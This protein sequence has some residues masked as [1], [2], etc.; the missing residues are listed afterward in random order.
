[1]VNSIPSSQ[2]IISVRKNRIHVYIEWRHYGQ[3]ALLTLRRGP[4][5]EAKPHQIVYTLTTRQIPEPTLRVANK[6]VFLTEDVERLARHFHVTPQWSVLESTDCGSDQGTPTTH[7]TLKQPFEVTLASDGAHEVR[8]GGGEIFAC[9]KDRGKAYVIAGLLDSASRMICVQLLFTGLAASEH[10][11]NARW[12][13][14]TGR[15]LTT[16]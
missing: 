2:W 4:H 12:E 6:R 14:T 5:F 11:R 7:L 10:K 16:N 15:R 8:D 9:C 13:K 3:P 1:M